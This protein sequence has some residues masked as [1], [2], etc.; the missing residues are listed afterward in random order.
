MAIRSQA[1]AV[2]FLTRPDERDLALRLDEAFN[3]SY[4]TRYGKQ[5][6][7]IAEPK[8]QV[9]ERFGL[10]NEVLVVYSEH[11]TTDARVLTTIET[12]SKSSEFKQ[13][14][15]KVLYIVIHKG[16]IAETKELM[17]RDLDRII[18]PIHVNELLDP[19][20]GSI[21]IRRRIAEYI[22]DV[23]LFGMSSPISSDKYFFGRDELVQSLVIRS[24]SRKENSGL[25]GL[26]KTGKTSV[27]KAFQRRVSER[28]ILVD[29]IDCANP[30]IHSARWWEV[31]ETLTQRLDRLKKSNRSPKGIVERPR[32]SQ[33]SAGAEFSTALRL[34]IEEENLEQI[35]LLL[36]EIEYITP[37]LSN[38]LGQHWDRDFVPF[39]QTIR[40]IHQELDGKL[41]F[42]VAGVNPAG[43][44]ETRIGET[45]NPIFQLAVPHFLEPFNSQSV[46]DMVRT[47][48]KY[49][50]LRFE[51]DV[52]EYLRAVY[53]G[54]PF[55]I[56]I[57]CSEVSRK[58][59]R[60]NPSETA[61]VSVK[62][63]VSANTEI[64][65][66]LSQPIK[67]ILLS[68][69]WWYPEDY[70]LLQIL[71]EGDEAFF[72]KYLEENPN[73]VV[74]FAKYGI[75][76]TQSQ[77][78]FAIADLQEFIKRYGAQYKSSISPFIRAD[79]PPE[80]LPEIPDLEALGK[81][82][83]K[84]SELEIKMRQAIL[85]YLGIRNNW[86]ASKIADAMAKALTKRRDRGDPSELFLG[87]KPQEVINE[88]YTLDLKRI[89]SDNWETFGSLFDSNK[90]RFEMN[91]DSVNVARQMDSHTKPV[92]PSEVEEFNNSYSW[93][94]TRLSKIPL[95][96]G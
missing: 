67:D 87:R 72:N 47:L 57:A 88:L 80:L 17:R 94:L 48:G 82:F 16:D 15:D 60:S 86:D 12:A 20:R 19:H 62:D 3:I 33:G 91:M 55:L 8:P 78:K 71:A 22:G 24:S 96:S 1:D 69:V 6:L 18:V 79:L 41:V 54:H 39:W 2:Y 26:R 85:L 43:V 95:I 23:D 49:S 28:P 29:Y 63:F 31:L 64:R 66:R 37:G 68:L 90:Q 77:G 83:V 42:L 5:S 25:F 13:R 36:D 11:L 44:E 21:F 45:P 93:I 56:R 34:L 53:G 7:W 73:S 14:I 35:V 92:T 89:V 4:G 70:D 10:Q 65:D 52:Y 74:Q 81:L 38:I 84:K 51:E 75:L 76:Q 30:G 61:K 59:D 9:R 40:S 46:R 27:L 58:I 32:Y 50:G